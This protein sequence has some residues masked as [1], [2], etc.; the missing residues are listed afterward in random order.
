MELVRHSFVAVGHQLIQ[1]MSGTGGDVDSAID[2][3]PGAGCVV[4]VCG[5]GWV[6]VVVINDNVVVV[7]VVIAFGGASAV[8]VGV[9]TAVGVRAG[10]V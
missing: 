1:I 7:V 10:G 4:V 3:E 9:P 8:V 6:V 2:L 5:G